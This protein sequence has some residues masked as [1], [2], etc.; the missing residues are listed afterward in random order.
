M[1]SQTLWQDQIA[2][3]IHGSAIDA[4]DETDTTFQTV[5]FYLN[6]Q[7]WAILSDLQ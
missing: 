6:V 3:N 4:I 5:S 1:C 2:S 7:K